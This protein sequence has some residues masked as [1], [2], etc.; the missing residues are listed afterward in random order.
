M[1][2]R[3]Y[4]IGVCRVKMSGGFKYI[5][6]PDKTNT[7]IDRKAELRDDGSILYTPIKKD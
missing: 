5:E 7:F 1:W 2:I 6:L 3:D 4:K